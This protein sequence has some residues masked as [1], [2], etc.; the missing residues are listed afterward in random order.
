MSVIPVAKYFS[1]FDTPEVN[2]KKYRQLAMD[3]HP[4]RHPNN[5]AKEKIFKEVADEYEAVY[6]F[7]K[8]FGVLNK[9]VKERKFNINVRRAE[10]STGVSVTPAAKKQSQKDYWDGVDPDLVVK[11]GE[12]LGDMLERLFKSNR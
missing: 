11:W 3:N 9:P 12:T 1:L 5:K 2:K 8:E 7:Q 10:R 4:D 6:K